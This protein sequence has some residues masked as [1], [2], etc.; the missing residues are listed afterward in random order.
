MQQST[1]VL[2][3]FE[4]AS[5]LNKHYDA[6]LAAYKAGLER[7]KEVVP[8]Q[9]NNF[10]YHSESKATQHAD[11]YNLCARDTEVAI[12]REIARLI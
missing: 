1:P 3:K 5:L 11:G 6:L 9:N 8:E 7:A 2:D 12:E 4:R 10:E